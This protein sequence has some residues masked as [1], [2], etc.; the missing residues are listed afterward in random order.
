MKKLILLTTFSLF[1]TISSFSQRTCG[2][3]E[4]LAQQLEQD[5]KRQDKMNRIER[6]TQ[7]FLK[8]NAA[9]RF[10]GVATI[11]VVVHVVYNS[12]AENISEAQINS[13][14]DILNEDF[15]RL[16]SD[17]SNTPADFIAKAADIEIEFCLAS[18]DPDGNPTNG[19]TRTS[20]TNTSFGTNDQVKFNSSGGKDAWPAADYL[21]VWVCD[22]SGGILGYAQF[23]GGS[24]STDGVVNDYQYF[25]NIGTATAPFDLG[26]TMTHEVGHYLNLRHIWGDG[27]CNAD[28]FVSDTPRAGGPN[29]SGAPC[30]YPGPNSCNEGSNDLA[31]M[32][33]NYMDY[34][35]DGCMNLFTD[36]QKARMRAIFDSGGARASL[37]SSNKCGTPAE[38]TCSDGIQNGDEQGIDCGG[39]ICAACPAK[40]SC[41][42]GV[43]NGSETGVDCGGPD[44]APCPCA[45]TDVTVII[46][47]DNYPE[48]TS[49]FIRN[50]SGSTVAS[51]GTY[52]SQ[53][54]GSTVSVD[55]CLADDCYDFIINDAYGDGICCSYGSGSYLVTAGGST[56]ASGGSFNSSETSNFCVGGP[57]GPTCDDGIQNGDETGVD[58]GGSTC[59][60]CPVIP[61][62]D[63]GIQNG[64]ETGLDCG[65]DCAPCPLEPTCSDGIQNGNETGVDCGGPDCS[66][67]DTGGCTNTNIDFNDFEAGFGIWNDGGSDCTLDT[68]ANFANSGNN[69]IRLRDNSTSS[70]TTTDILALSGFT[71]VTI[72]F[73]YLAQGM[74]T[75]EDFWLQA[76]ID[77]GASYQTLIT[78][79][80]GSDF[81][82]FAREYETVTITGNF[83]NSTRFRF[84]CNASANNDLVYLDDINI[85]GC[86]NGNREDEKKPSDLILQE[87]KLGK[88][89]V[90]PNPTYSSLNV[91][92]NVAI[93]GQV[94]INV[95]DMSG[96]RL[97]SQ[98]EQGQ[99]GVNTAKVHVSNL[100]PGIY[101]IHLKNGEKQ[102]IKKF[103]VLK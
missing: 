44:C 56:V 30:T 62:C 11:P 9:Q 31:D 10:N 69:T 73:T 88:V 40:P 93:E 54:D 80:S 67:C 14:I 46:V 83:T 52:G 25:G 95:I 2:A 48:E 98:L 47:L 92:Y 34:S 26:R 57:S 96:R 91:E 17:A 86:T 20:T 4:V 84:R 18:I 65:G 5:P 22:I 19:I 43:Q 103:V 35:N 49:W 77:G 24:P 12:S 29:Y 58:C 101:Y 1:L 6:A 75:G 70:V 100:T 51:G 102:I 28:D 78:W 41:S 55:L 94:Q 15:R 81:T 32:F 90:Y 23:P 72:D 60:D 99:Q 68:R 3:M 38:P 50:S 76:S 16:N 82:N 37:L 42:D 39:S 74:E 71:E 21:N 8:K 63:D 33:Q 13:Q 7:A 36:G 97:I 64:N 45:G 89:K 27:N 79:T 59:S 66:P 53:P 87:E 61:T 85:S